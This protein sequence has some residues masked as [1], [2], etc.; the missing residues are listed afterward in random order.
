M[1]INLS[2]LLHRLK[3]IIIKMRRVGNLFKNMYAGN[4]DKFEK[5]VLNTS[6]YL[7][8]GEELKDDK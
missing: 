5:G 1:K 3:F 7:D 6:H 2:K 8:T 4:L